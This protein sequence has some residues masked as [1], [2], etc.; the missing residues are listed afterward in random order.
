MG[1]P[2]R[3]LVLRLVFIVFLTSATFAQVSDSYRHQEQADVAMLAAIT[4]VD[5]STIFFD[6]L[7]QS[8]YVRDGRFYELD[9]Q[10]GWPHEES[11]CVGPAVS[12]DGSRVAYGTFQKNDGKVTLLI[13]DLTA[14]KERSLGE[15]AEYERGAMSWSWD[16]TEIAY[17]GKHGI[18]AISVADGKQRLL[19]RLPLR[20][21]GQVPTEGWDIRSLNWL[22]GRPEL[23]LDTEICNPTKEKGTC[24]EQGESLLFSSDDSH[25]LLMGK[26]GAVSPVA[27]I[28]AAGSTDAI[29][30]VDSNGSNRRIITKVP[31][32][33]WILPFLKEELWNQIVWSPT[34][35]RLWFST[36]IDE[37][38]NANV[39]LVDVKSGKR[40]RILKKTLI[41]ITAWRK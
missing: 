23:V 1:L 31:V 9:I 2:I 35:D 36:I 8:G 38:G 4:K 15:L 24:I 32:A 14:G 13:R 19:G 33:L 27:N 30:E 5:H 10:C 34:G 41:T 16:D 40:K 20:I 11:H 3:T 21:D 26:K 39:Y 25:V 7:T 17:Q 28:V 22:H 18:F 12:H 29:E 37:G 6:G